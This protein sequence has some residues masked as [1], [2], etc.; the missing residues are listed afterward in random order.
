M[1]LFEK[2]TCSLIDY[3]AEHIFLWKQG[4]ARGLDSQSCPPKTY[5][6]ENST[7]IVIEHNHRMCFCGKLDL[8]CCIWKGTLLSM[9]TLEW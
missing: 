9:S 8:I 1:D 4:F 2:F 7:V 5:D 6:I 3:E